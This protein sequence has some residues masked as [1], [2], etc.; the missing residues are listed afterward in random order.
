MTMCSLVFTAVRRERLSN[1][2][3]K[4]FVR[5]ASAVKRRLAVWGERICTGEFVSR[6]GWRVKPF[7][8]TI[9][10]NA[11]SLYMCV[12]CVAPEYVQAERGF[13]MGSR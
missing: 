11:A 3:V 4:P 8:C 9:W 5:T 10:S 7:V 6:G 13:T 2:G 1:C 12:L